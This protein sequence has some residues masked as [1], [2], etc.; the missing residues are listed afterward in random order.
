MEGN[1]ELLFLDIETAP[2]LA[3]IWGMYEQNALDF[4]SECYIMCYSAKWGKKHIVKG[5]PDYKGYSPGTENDYPLVKEVWDLLNNAEVVCW[6]NGDEFDKKKINT[7]FV[8]WGLG[9]PSPYKTIDTKKV[10]KR[11]F[12]FN[13]NALDNMGQF[14]GLGRKIKHEG[15]ELWQKCLKGDLKAWNRMKKYCKNDITLL[16]KLY[17]RFVPWIQTHPNLWKDR[18]ACPKCGSNN[19]QSRGYVETNT[20]KYRRIQCNSC[21]GWS[22]CTEN[23]Q[24]VKP[25]VS[26]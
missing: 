1:K 18:I 11:Y 7:R 4:V 24:A 22:R 2:N 25:L 10:A 16:E 15:F 14:L 19:I 21:K 20:T 3:H 23:L 5:L 26:I 6:Q 12:A 8:Y 17:L 13:S 9:P